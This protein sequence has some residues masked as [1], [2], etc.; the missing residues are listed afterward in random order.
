MSVTSVR[1]TCS[2]AAAT[3]IGATRRYPSVGIC[4]SDVG[5]GRPDEILQ[6]DEGCGVALTVSLALACI[7]AIIGQSGGQ[8]IADVEPAETGTQNASETDG[9]SSATIIRLITTALYPIRMV[10]LYTQFQP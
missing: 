3:F 8:R 1:E 2:I 9:A 7:A 10:A 5:T 6:Q 4:S